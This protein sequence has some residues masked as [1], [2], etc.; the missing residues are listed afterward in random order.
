MLL[1]LEYGNVV[2]DLNLGHQSESIRI[3]GPHPRKNVAF[4]LILLLHILLFGLYLH[5]YIQFNLFEQLHCCFGSYVVGKFPFFF[6]FFKLT[7]LVFFSLYIKVKG[8]SWK[9]K[10]VVLMLDFQ[11]LLRVYFAVWIELIW[12]T[13]FVAGIQFVK[14]SFNLL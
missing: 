12:F 2:Q 4:P 6:L 3:S 8:W 7:K 13:S 9:L 1:L 11:I 10:W 5:N 14:V